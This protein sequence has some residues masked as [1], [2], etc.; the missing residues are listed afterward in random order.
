ML[1]ENQKHNIVSWKTKKYWFELDKVND[2]S[3]ENLNQSRKYDVC[4][5]TKTTTPKDSFLYIL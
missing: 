5:N 3:Y 4:F 2:I 1:L